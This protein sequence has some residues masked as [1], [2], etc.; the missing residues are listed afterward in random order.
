MRYGLVYLDEKLIQL[1]T[2]LELF[3]QELGC[4][5]LTGPGMRHPIL[6]VT[7]FRGARGSFSFFVDCSK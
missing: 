6:D 2:L 4:T 5:A 3:S 1:T 7:V